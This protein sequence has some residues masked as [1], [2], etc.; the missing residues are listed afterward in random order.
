MAKIEVLERFSKSTDGFTVKEYVGDIEVS[1]SAPYYRQNAYKRI[2]KRFKRYWHQYL[3]T[4]QKEDKTYRYYLTEKGK[5]RLE[6]LQ[7]IETEVIE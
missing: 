7:K 4:R 3:L 6:Y 1:L 5:K 2:E